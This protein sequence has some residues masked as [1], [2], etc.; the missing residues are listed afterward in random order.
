MMAL[1]D[2]APR[3]HDLDVVDD[4]T[5]SPASARSAC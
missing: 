1:A 4:L 5:L 2:G 3:C